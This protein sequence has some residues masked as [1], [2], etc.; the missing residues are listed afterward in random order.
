MYYLRLT[1]A[2][3]IIMITGATSKLLKRF[4]RSRP[5]YPI[6]QELQTF[7]SPTR[8]HACIIKLLERLKHALF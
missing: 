4:V 8:L 5:F 7:Y 3:I 2:W 1:M 6:K